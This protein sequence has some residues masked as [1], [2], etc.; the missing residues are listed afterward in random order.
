MLTKF[1]YKY[2]FWF[3][4][5]WYQ[6]SVKLSKVKN[7]QLKKFDHAFEIVTALDW[8][9]KWKR[10]P[11]FGIW[12]VMPHPTKVQ[13]K[14]NKNVLID[15]CDGHAVYWATNILYSGIASKAWIA[16]V[17]MKDEKGS[18]SGHCVCLYQNFKGKYFWCDY[19]MPRSFDNLENF[20]WVEQVCKNRNSKPAAAGIFE[21]KTIKED[22]T[23]VFS[24]K[25]VTKTY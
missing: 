20:E 21:V 14:I 17:H 15:D 19:T 6:T 18:I 16:T 12:D 24:K 5:F 9:N 25:T 10:D 4:R 23:P 7:V 8:G 11:I 2:F 22:F 13:D 3:A 1:G